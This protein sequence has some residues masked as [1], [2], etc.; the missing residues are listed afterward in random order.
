ML[1]VNETD[2][3]S[4][5]KRLVCAVSDVSMNAVTF[6]VHDLIVER[7]ICQLPDAPNGV[8][9]FTAPFND[10]VHFDASVKAV[11]ASETEAP[12]PASA[13]IAFIPS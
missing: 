9:S 12:I 8:T 4:N 3:P 5:A 7:L 2:E 10:N 13:L 1:S 11:E 6:A